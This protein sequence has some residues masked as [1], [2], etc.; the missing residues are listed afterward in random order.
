LHPP[1]RFQIVDVQGNTSSRARHS[2][3]GART[4]CAQRASPL[5]QRNREETLAPVPVPRLWGRAGTRQQSTT[6]GGARMAGGAAEAAAEH[7]ELAPGARQLLRQKQT[8]G[9][10]RQTADGRLQTADG[11][12]YGTWPSR[13]HAWL[14]VSGTGADAA[15]RGVARTINERAARLCCASWL[16]RCDTGGPS[17]L[18]FAELACR[19]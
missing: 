14:F 17:S 2:R 13:S 16:T 6:A 5:S 18:L 9:G 11:A 8:A 7:A 10:R 1:S 19:N 15:C 3:R 4:T 12:Y